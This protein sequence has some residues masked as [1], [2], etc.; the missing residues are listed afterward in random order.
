MYQNLNLQLCINLS[1]FSFCGCENAKVS[2]RF[3]FSPLGHYSSDEW[4]CFEL[5][6]NT[7]QCVGGVT[8]V[9]CI[10]FLCFFKSQNTL[11]SE[12]FSADPPWLYSE[13]SLALIFQLFGTQKACFS[14]DVFLLMCSSM[15]CS[16]D[17]LL[18]I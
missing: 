16:Y 3:Y 11:C 12:I 17:V 9:T 13:K 6:A 15:S 8:D 5:V 2:F 18:F 14:N 10:D 4:L 7:Q 1:H